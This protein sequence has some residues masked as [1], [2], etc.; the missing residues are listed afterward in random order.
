MPNKS[1]LEK[2]QQ[3][4]KELADKIRLAKTMILADFRGLTVD[5][6]TELRRALRNAGVEYRV[7][8]NTLIKFAVKEN[9]I[10]GLD[11]FLNGPTSVAMSYDDHVAPAK[12][13]DEYAKKFGKVQFKA[14]VVEG[15]VINV[16]E[17]RQL[18]SLPPREQLIARV[19]GGFSA[20]MAGLVSVLAANIR[21]LAI[22]L[23][24][25]AQK[26]AEA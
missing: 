26:K 25:I 15:K 20:P 18:A 11:E 6:D 19:L 22:A 17:I 16:D 2:K 5:Q 24:Q 8:K 23:N 7:I 14:G 1:V 9:G 10:E 3:V 21:G 4:V 13:L 12:V